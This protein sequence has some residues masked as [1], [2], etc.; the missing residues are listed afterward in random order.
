M[1]I[2][3]KHIG[4]NFDDFLKEQGIYDEV[5]DMAAKRRLALQFARQMKKKKITK[6]LMAKKMHTSRMQI[7][8]I[9]SADNSAISLDTLE[10]AAQVLG[11]RLRLELI[12]A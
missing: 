8:R 12:S 10:R 7:N 4:G 3:E 11:C 1:P 5:M 6:T 2:N 9:F